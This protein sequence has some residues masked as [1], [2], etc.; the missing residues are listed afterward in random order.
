VTSPIA[1]VGALAFSLLA[2]FAGVTTTRPAAPFV[3]A[4]AAFPEPRDA[5]RELL[6]ALDLDAEQ[7]Q[8]IEAL[9]ERERGRVDALQRAL[10]RTEGELRRSELARPFDAERVNEL[11]ARQAELVAY[12]RGTESRVVSEIAAL[13]G[14]AQQRRFA[15]LRGAGAT[16]LPRKPELPEAEKPEER[17]RTPGI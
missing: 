2:L 17:V 9:R 14:P 6:A 13:L 3:R 4:S 7:R 10:D 16:R 11:V 15:E 5:E 1:P 8:R 12:L